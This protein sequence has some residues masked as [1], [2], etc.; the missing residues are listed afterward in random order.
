MVFC[1]EKGYGRNM[2][3]F[4]FRNSARKN[5]FAACFDRLIDLFQEAKQTRRSRSQH[6]TGV[7]WLPGL[8]NLPRELLGSSKPLR[9]SPFL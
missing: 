9:R 2:G 4:W 7:P 1:G 8:I 5:F 6:F 3:K